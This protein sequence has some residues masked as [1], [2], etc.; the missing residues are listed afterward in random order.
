MASHSVVISWTASVDVVDG[1]NVLRSS[2]SGGPYTKINAALVSGTT[3]TDSGPFPNLGPFFYV[4]ESVHGA[5]SSIPSNESPA[6]FLPPLPPTNL[7]VSS[8]S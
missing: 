3:F 2:T 7:L 1:Y 8:V 4:A 6:V 5:T